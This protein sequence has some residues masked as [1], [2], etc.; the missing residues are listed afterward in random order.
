MSTLTSKHLRVTQELE[1]ARESSDVLRKETS[2]LIQK[3]TS[4]KETIERLRAKVSG[5][6][7]T[8]QEKDALLFEENSEIVDRDQTIEKL[9]RDKVGLAREIES[10]QETIV[11]HRQRK[12]TTIFQEA[13]NNRLRAT[14]IETT[15]E[16]TSLALDG[17]KKSA[18][19]KRT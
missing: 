18:R 17:V 7:T 10:L 6:E 5:L 8:I 13:Q 2:F 3:D 9:K 12:M 15:L 14:K 19:R 16:S 1:A 11:Q 4:Q